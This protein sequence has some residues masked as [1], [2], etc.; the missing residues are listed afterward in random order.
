MLPWLILGVLAVVFLVVGA[1][2]MSRNRRA[3]RPVEETAAEHERTEHE[4]EEAE[5]YQ[6]QWRKDHPDNELIP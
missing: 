1:G 4:F 6:E 5:R 2:A 3:E